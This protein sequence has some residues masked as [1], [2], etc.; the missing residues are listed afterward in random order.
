VVGKIEVKL[1]G[2]YGHRRYS[3]TGCKMNLNE[4]GVRD[5]NGMGLG[6]MAN[7]CKHGNESSG[8]IKARELLD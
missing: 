7:S 2:R 4:E 3:S 8:S 1:H 6:S 5:M